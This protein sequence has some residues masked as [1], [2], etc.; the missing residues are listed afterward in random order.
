MDNCVEK[1]CICDHDF[2]KVQRFAQDA[3]DMTHSAIMVEEC[4]VCFHER[5][6]ETLEAIDAYVLSAEGQTRMFGK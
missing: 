6:F 1:T 2:Q 4:Q 3:L 5:G